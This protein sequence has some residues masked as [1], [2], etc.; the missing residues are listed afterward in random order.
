MT[1][2]T[3]Q[4]RR[5]FGRSALTVWIV[6][7][8]FG[9]A[10][11]NDGEG[12][13]GMNPPAGA[14]PAG[15]DSAANAPD[16]TDAARATIRLDAKQRQIAGLT[17]GTAERRALD[18]VV[19]TVGRFDVDERRVAA[20]A[21]KVGGYVEKLFV[22][23]TGRAVRRGE[24]LFSIYSPDLVSAEQEY[25]LA[26]QTQRA[27]ANSQVPSA[28]QSAASLVR[29]SRE[30]LRLWDLTEP[31]IRQ[32]EES[33]TASLHRII[34]S[35]V[36][37]IVLEK[38]VIAGQSVQAGMTLFRIADLSTIWVY[39]DVYEYELPF[40]KVGQPAE[41]RPSYAPGRTLHATVAYVYP[42]LDPKTRTARV[43]FDL[44]NT[45]DLLLRPEMY[46]NVE[47]HVP[48]GER[49]VVPKSAVLD[50]GRRQL[51]FVAAA[52]GRLAPREVKIGD[53][54]DDWVEVREGLSAGDH[55][56]ISANFLVDSESQLQ[57]AESMMGMM[58]AIG[59]GDWKME[60]A[61]PMSMGGEE[62]PP[63]EPMPATNGEG[64]AAA[65]PAEEKRVGDLMISVF[66]AAAS[67]TVGDS[68]IRVRV[69][70]S[71]GA[72]VQQ[73]KVTLNYT[74][75]MP[76]MSIASAEAQPR[77][78]GTYEGIAKFTMGGP[79]SVVV[80]IERPGKPALRERFVVRVGG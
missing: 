21:L 8:F 15:N 47:L 2:E 12:T 26:L 10:S 61:K 80:Q 78:D 67:A 33:G 60:S 49:L 54:V 37:G 13:A 11:A 35:P 5:A 7:V 1:S 32:L 3:L 27:L 46:G 38:M 50:S 51:V 9:V 22:D 74:M 76:G 59:M 16:G 77:G 42:T 25:L 72:P 66:P 45:E 29:A 43:R 20:V 30:R 52:G 64:A 55:V 68:A 58:G 23:Y 40:V 28:S 36:S 44:T 19:R 6:A 31:Q 48:L 18:K 62:P 24:P 34:R 75:D 39:G 63:A 57:A 56:V 73:A 4:R 41:I 17:F 79:W 71:S 70:D 14:R 65:P 69:R 53:R